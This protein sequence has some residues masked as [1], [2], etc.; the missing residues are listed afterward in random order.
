MTTNSRRVAALATVTLAMMT[1]A[2]VAHGQG[3]YSRFLPRTPNVG[4][5]GFQYSGGD[6]QML[7]ADVTVGG[8]RVGE[9]RLDHDT[10]TGTTARGTASGGSVL[11]GGFWLDGGVGLNDGCRL[12]WTQVVRTEVPGRNEWNA[13]R[14][15]WFPDTNNG[16]MSPD[17]PGQVL[18]RL[19][20]PP[21]P[22]PNAAFQDFPFRFF[23]DGAQTWQAELGLF[24][25]RDSESEI[26]LIGS[27]TWGFTI[28][29]GRNGEPNQVTRLGNPQWVNG[30]A[31]DSNLARTLTAAFGEN[32][33]NGQRPG[34]QWTINT[35]VC[36]DCFRP[37]PA[38]GG[39]GVLAFGLVVAARRRRAG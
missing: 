34:R 3:D 37:L 26:C 20:T 4:L 28:T 5:T 17:Y 7:N 27:I 38:P 13:G 1:L 33:I 32:G 16:R 18:P 14:N 23:R 25:M 9:V 24:A 30:V 6:V 36:E 15:T 8:R 39:V 11:C 10:F 19:Q 29:P 12:G 35:G 22:R 31:A 2:G 21:D